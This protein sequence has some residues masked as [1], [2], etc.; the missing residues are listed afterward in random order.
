MN[1]NVK[2]LAILAAVG[3][4]CASALFLKA[5]TTIPAAK[6]QAGDV[7]WIGSLVTG[8]ESSDIVGGPFPRADK[9]V[10]IGLR[11]DGVVVWRRASKAN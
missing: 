3:L 6:T 9:S 11:S 2:I 8:V 5:D 1:L 4:L 10:E 7:T